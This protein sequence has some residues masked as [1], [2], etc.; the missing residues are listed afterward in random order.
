MPVHVPVRVLVPVHVHD[1]LPSSA[2]TPTPLRAIVMSARG[3][4]ASSAGSYASTEQSATYR[5]HAC[6]DLT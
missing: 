5:M 2:A 1:T 4:H 6:A 3:A